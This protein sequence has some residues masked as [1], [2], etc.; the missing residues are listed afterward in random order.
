MELISELPTLPEIADADMALM[1]LR[2]LDRQV[3]PGAKP[4]VYNRA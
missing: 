4:S 3:A 2:H 1:Y